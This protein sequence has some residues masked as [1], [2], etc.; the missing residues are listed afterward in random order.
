LDKPGHPNHTTPFENSKNINENCFE[1]WKARDLQQ[2]LE[3]SEF[4]N[5]EPVIQKAIKACETSGHS[6]LDH[7]VEVHDMINIGK[8]A[9]REVRD[10][11]LSRYACYLVIQ[12]A[13]PAKPMVALGQTYFAIQTRKQEVFEQSGEDE[14]RLMLREEL[15]KHNTFLASAANK[16]GVVTSLE[17]A[18]FQN[19]GY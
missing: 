14:K 5:F 16:A 3:Y 9:K 11:H 1:F 19:H 7:F 18:I 2:I 4:R 6:A 8:G 13:D 10:Y 15:K 12:N 17:F